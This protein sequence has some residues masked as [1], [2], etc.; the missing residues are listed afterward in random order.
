MSISR[1]SSPGNWLVLI[2]E[3]LWRRG[4]RPHVGLGL[5]VG[6]QV[7]PCRRDPGRVNFVARLH[8]GTRCEYI[9]YQVLKWSDGLPRTV[10]ECRSAALSS[11]RGIP[12]PERV[13]PSKPLLGFWPEGPPSN[14][15]FLPHRWHHGRHNTVSRISQSIFGKLYLTHSENADVLSSDSKR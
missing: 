11:G 3:D 5:G 14:R 13:C 4:T 2:S 6:V 8:R 7:E 9:S 12:F 15:N 10:D 1:L